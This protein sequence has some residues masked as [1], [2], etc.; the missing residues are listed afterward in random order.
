M[1][2]RKNQALGRIQFRIDKLAAN[3]SLGEEPLGFDPRGFE[4]YSNCH[5]TTLWVHGAG[6][7][8]FRPVLVWDDEMADFLSNC[9]RE[10]ERKDSI[11]GIVAFV[12]SE[13]GI[14]HTAIPVDLKYDDEKIFHQADM[15]EKFSYSTGKRYINTFF[16][17]HSPN[18]QNIH[19]NYY[20]V[21]PR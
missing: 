4:S 18:C 2:K 12:D 6:P 7:N 16:G 21:I 1:F 5:G 8:K 20:Q 14:Q 11:G 10:V 13:G 9:C 19:K 3:P 15:G 17:I